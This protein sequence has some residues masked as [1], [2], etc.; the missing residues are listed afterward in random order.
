MFT[1]IVQ[2]FVPVVSS[3]VESGVLRLGLKMGNLT[4][5]LQNGASVAVNGVCLTVTGFSPD[6]VHFDVLKKPVG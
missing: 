3:K 5:G 1:G 6:L 4:G 2:G